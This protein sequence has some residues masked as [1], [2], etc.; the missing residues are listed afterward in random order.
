[1]TRR[2]RPLGGSGES[3]CRRKLSWISRGLIGAGCRLISIS[4]DLLWCGAPPS[5]SSLIT[6]KYIKDKIKMRE[7][8]TGYSATSESGIFSHIPAVSNGWWGWKPSL[9]YKAKHLEYTPLDIQD[10]SYPWDA[11]HWGLINKFHQQVFQLHWD[12]S[13]KCS[14]GNLNDQSNRKGSDCDGA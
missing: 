6:A 3:R 2:G 8:T 12:I 4:P 1:M 9:N 13:W 7:N 10:G 11:K 14:K 5:L